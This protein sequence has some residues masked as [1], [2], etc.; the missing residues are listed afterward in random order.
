MAAKADDKKL[1]AKG[2]SKIALSKSAKISQASQYS[3]IAVLGAGIFLGAA[4][5]LVSQFS[6]QIA[7]NADV[8]A[9]A[10]KSIVDYSNAIKSAGV[11]PKPKNNATVYSGDELKNCH[12]NSVGVYQVPG[13]LRSNILQTI[14]AN[15]ALNSVPKE[16]SSSCINPFT[17][18]NYTYSELQGYYDAAT[19][20]DELAAATD[21]IQ[22]CS[23]LRVIPDALPPYRNEAALLTGLN[24]IFDISGWEPESISPTGTY[25]TAEFDP[26][27]NSVSVQFTVDSTYSTAMSVLKNI[28]RSIRGFTFTKATIEWSGESSMSLHAQADAYY[29]ASS[30]YTDSSTT[31]TGDEEQ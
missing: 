1:A 23:A 4:V 26:D 22:N 27:L 15:A 31:I 24:K 3:L 18:K 7:F 21:L 13:T 16:D 19:T 9:A 28:E 29:I 30:E 10:D 14:A 25:G 11:C 5:A 20:D 6:N 17:N 2:L 8:I 12:P